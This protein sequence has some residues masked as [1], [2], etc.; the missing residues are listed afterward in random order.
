MNDL[1]FTT[2]SDYMN[3]SR[4]QK[5][6]DTAVEE[7]SSSDFE[8]Y[9]SGFANKFAELVVQECICEIAMAGLSNSESEDISSTCLMIIGN[10]RNKFK[11][12]S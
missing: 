9:P 11:N 7:C 10:I 6:K 5:L 12:D 8:T 3:Y 4:I 1:K 2:A